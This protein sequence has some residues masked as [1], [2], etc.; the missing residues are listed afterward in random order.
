MIQNN[1]KFL[2]TTIYAEILINTINWEFKPMQIGIHPVNPNLKK[3]NEILEIALQAEKYDFAGF[4]FDDTLT[5]N[6]YTFESFS[7]LASIAVQTNTIKIGHDVIAGALRHPALLAKSISTLDNIANGRYEIQIGAGIEDPYK[8]YNLMDGPIIPTVGEQVERFE[9]T[10]KILNLMLTQEITDFEGKYWKLQGAINR[11]LP[12]QN[13]MKIIVGCFGSRMMRITAK[14][15]QGIDIFAGMF[16]NVE[17]SINQARKFTEI[18][19]KAGKSIADFEIISSSPI[20]IDQDEQK[21]IQLAQQLAKTFAI[22][23]DKVNLDECLVGTPEKIIEKYEI[24]EDNNIDK[25]IIGPVLDPSIKEPVRYLKENV[26]DI[27]K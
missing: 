23:F 25:I 22:D 15:A 19:E 14:Y 9:E 18:V 26:V 27:L 10:L 4:Y 3:Y 1:Q 5:W 2:I 12:L 13:P 20:I 17:T 21:A 8:M 6:P 7:T 16:G 11:P 24:L